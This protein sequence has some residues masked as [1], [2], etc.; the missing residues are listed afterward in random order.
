MSR[1]VIG[2][3]KD[4]S[5]PKKFWKLKDGDA[6]YGILPP[7]GDLAAS[8]IWSVYYRVHYGYK[9]AEGK[10][11]PFQSTLV[12]N[13]KSKMIEVPD[14]AC[15][16]LDMLNAQLKA[17]KESG[18]DKAKEAL[19][20][21][22]G[23][24]KSIYNLDSN[25]HINA[26]DLQGNIG[27]LKLRHKAKLALQVEID[28]LCAKGQDPRGVENRRFFVFS[29]SGMA[30][31]TNYKVTIYKEK[32]TVDGVG[33][34][35]RD[36]V[37]CLTDEVLDRLGDEAAKLDSLYKTPNADQIEQIVKSSI[38]TTGIC[39]DIDAILGTNSSQATSNT[40][41]EFVDDV[42][43]DDTPA[44]EAVAAPAIKPKITPVAAPTPVATAPVTP[45]APAVAAPTPVATA[46]ATA[47]KPVVKASPITTA[48]KIEDMTDAAFFESL[49]IP[50]QG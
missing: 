39:K 1:V 46:P 12:E 21:L 48:D 19:L 20:K 45:A 31:E 18:N 42:P 17:A 15:E 40:T 24:Q 49:G 11:R 30:N 32:L 8:G 14:A 33:E 27:V 29:R 44:M 4:K 38:L 43:G 22:V 50:S 2:K 41:E 34:V 5:A 6:V 47:S 36:F 13:R 16:R 28:K 25:H 23:G 35:E 3:A 9:N 7:I 37:N 26:I 10:S